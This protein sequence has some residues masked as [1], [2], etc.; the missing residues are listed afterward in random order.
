MSDTSVKGERSFK[1]NLEAL[2]DELSLAYQW[3]RPSLLLAV[4]K[5][6]IGQEK[7]RQA[8]QQKLEE[9]G[10]RVLSITIDEA[11]PDAAVTLLAEEKPSEPV[12][13]VQGLERGGGVDGRDAYY[14]LNLSRE[15]FVENQLKVVFWLAPNEAAALTQDFGLTPV[16][17]TARMYTGAI[18][19]LRLERVFGVTTF[20][21]G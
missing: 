19:P 4:N 20:E 21:L 8:L 15:L 6:G 12:F 14:A 16:F 5:S 10:R 13:F 18:P 1:A 2:Y 7:A 17:E 9:A 11:Q 3:G